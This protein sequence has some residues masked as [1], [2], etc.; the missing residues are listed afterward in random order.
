MKNLILLTL[1][2]TTFFACTKDENFTFEDGTYK[3]SEAEFSYGWKAY[4]Q[5]SISEDKLTMV[6]FDALDEDGNKKSE[7]TE[8][9]YPMTPHPSVW[10]PQYQLSLMDADILNFS[11]ID[12]ISGATNSNNIT[13]IMMKVLLEAAKTGNTEE[14]IIAKDS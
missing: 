2:I 6:D 4:L 8:D 12:A 13:T 14:I 11:A 5:V 7:T 3:V 10:L 1:L 9:E